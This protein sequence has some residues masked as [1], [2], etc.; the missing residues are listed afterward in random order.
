MAD[1]N[2]FQRDIDRIPGRPSLAPVITMEVA[3]NRS[4]RLSYPVLET[5]IDAAAA[6]WARGRDAYLAWFEMRSR[7][8]AIR[9]LQS[10][11][12]RTLRDIGL[13]RADIFAAVLRGRQP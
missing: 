6:L 7:A 11:D 8:L 3:M 10:L 2:C 13:E 1:T 5:A 4:E 12:D 9:Q